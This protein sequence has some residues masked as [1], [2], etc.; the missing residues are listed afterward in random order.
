MAAIVA[1]LCGPAFAQAEQPP[2]RFVV[3]FAAGGP[4]DA[5]A[6]IIAQRLEGRLG[7]TVQIENRGGAG[8]TTGAA[9]VARS[10]PDGNTV[11]ATTSAVVT[12][13]LLL[14]NA[15]YDAVTDL[16]GVSAVAKA[17]FVVLASRKSGI[18][19]LAELASAAKS[20]QLNFG[21][22]GI[23]TPIHLGTEYLMQTLG[24][25]MT[26][27]PFPGS[28]QALNALAGGH[29]DVAVDAALTGLAAAAGDNIRALAVTTRQRVPNGPAVPTVAELGHQGFEASAWYGLL[30]PAATP[31]AIIGELRKQVAA[32][33]DEPALEPRITSLGAE[34]YRVSG[35]E[36]AKVIR[37]EAKLWAGVIKAAGLLPN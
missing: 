24:I 5:V 21:S 13:P 4:A 35:D 17:G 12:A 34:V 37:D 20:R 19:S 9:A 16:V 22:S 8:G 1:G 15:G 30:V 25:K 7:R 3:P 14:K 6:R 29:I 36:F 23:G 27:V 31:N 10:A 28:S 2:L 33:L 11:L 26:H 32:V 18:T